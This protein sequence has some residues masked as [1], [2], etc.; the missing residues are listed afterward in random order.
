MI[1]L[2]DEQ[3]RLLD[4]RDFAEVARV[5][6]I[7]GTNPQLQIVEYASIMGPNCEIP[8]DSG[9]K[10]TTMYR[11]VLAACRWVANNITGT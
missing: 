1:V 11:N 3:E 5:P 4:L 6:L 2:W 9:I 10:S 8:P 7:H